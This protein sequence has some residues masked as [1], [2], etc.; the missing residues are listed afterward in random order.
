MGTS[1]ETSLTSHQY[2][3]CTLFVGGGSHNLSVYSWLLE[4]C[5][6]LGKLLWGHS[7]ISVTANKE[8]LL[9]LESDPRALHPWEGVLV[10]TPPLLP[11]FLSELPD[12][13]ERAGMG[14]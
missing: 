1:P 5:F 14:V 12:E 11:C 9:F 6:S 13:V 4:F 8:S 3:I 2:R 10:Y 7:E